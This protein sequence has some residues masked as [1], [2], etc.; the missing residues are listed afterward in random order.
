MNALLILDMQI[1]LRHDPDK[2]M[3]GQSLLETLNS[4]RSKARSAYASIF[5]SCHIGPPGSPGKN[6]TF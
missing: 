4:L 6:V 1:G 3:V 5:L 2:P